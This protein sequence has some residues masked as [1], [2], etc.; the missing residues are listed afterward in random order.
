[1]MKT[2]K[3]NKQIIKCC[4]FVTRQDYQLNM[5][6]IK[7]SFN[8]INY[9]F[10]VI[11]HNY[12]N[13]HMCVSMT[14]SCSLVDGIL[15]S[16]ALLYQNQCTSIQFEKT[17]GRY[18]KTLYPVHYI[19]VL[20]YRVKKTIIYIIGGTDNKKTTVSTYMKTKVH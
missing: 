18:F 1:M 15:L 16:L 6:K 5:M 10:V 9:M 2:N 7:T 12:I 3:K 4:C 11:L 20:Q 13:M 14:S 19:I 8:F 17:N